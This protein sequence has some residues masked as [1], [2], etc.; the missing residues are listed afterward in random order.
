MRCRAPDLAREAES[1]LTEL[2]SKYS[3]V[4]EVFRNGRMVLVDT[5][6]NVI[7]DDYEEDPLVVKMAVCFDT[8]CWDTAMAL[9]KHVAA[10]CKRDGLPPRI[11]LRA[12]LCAKR[13]VFCACWAPSTTYILRPSTVR[14]KFEGILATTRELMQILWSRALLLPLQPPHKRKR[15]EMEGSVM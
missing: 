14:A 10:A 1:V 2:A 4:R 8:A 12:A 11:R 9:K 3:G 6:D 15:E 13:L 7:D 5:A